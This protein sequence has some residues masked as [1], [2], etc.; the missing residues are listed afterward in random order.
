MYAVLKRYLPPLTSTACIAATSLVIAYPHFT[1]QHPQYIRSVVLANVTRTNKFTN[2]LENAVKRAKKHPFAAI[3]LEATGAG[4]ASEYE[5][6]ISMARFFRMYGLSNRVFLR[7]HP[8]F[9]PSA[10]PLI[11]DELLTLSR[12][13]ILEGDA[14]AKMRKI[15]ELPSMPQCFSIPIRPGKTGR[16]KRLGPIP[17]TL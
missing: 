11:R 2:Y 3:V 13:G 16:C 17:A 4:Q 7:M 14:R 10:I 12:T 15:E 8:P 9:E 1:V 6:I 5:P